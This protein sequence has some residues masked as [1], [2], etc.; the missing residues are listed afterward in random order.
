MGEAKLLIGDVFDRIEDIEPGSIDLLLTSPPFWKLRNY[1]PSDHPDKAKEIGQEPTPGEYL[2][3]MLRLV[4]RTATKLA[5]HGSVCV[6]IGDTFA[7][8][9]G[10]GGDYAEGGLRDGQPAFNGSGRTAA[11]SKHGVDP[12]RPGN[13]SS[14]TPHGGTQIPD[15]KSLCLIPTLFAAS[16]AYGRNL[17]TGEPLESGKWLV[18]NLVVWARP[19]P[20]VGDLG[21]K[22]RPGTSYMTIATR[23]RDRYFDLD[24]VRVPPKSKDDGGSM[25]N[26]KAKAAADEVLGAGGSGMFNPNGTPPLDWWEPWPIEQGLWDWWSDEVWKIVAGGYPGAHYACVDDK[27]E[28]LTPNGWKRHDELV[29]GDVI[30]AYDVDRDSWTWEPATFHRYPFAGDLVS[31][32]KRVTSQRLTPN[33][34]VIHRT[35]KLPM[36][37]QIRRADELVAGGTFLPVSAPMGGTCVDGPGAKM[38]ALAGWMITEGSIRTRQVVLYQSETANPEK[39][40]AIQELLD[41]VGAD[42][43]RR[44]RRS[45]AEFVVRGA[46]AERLRPFHK[47]L[48]WEVVATWADED[49]HALFDAM[50]DGDGHRR[51]DGRVSFIQKDR[52]T[53][54][55]FQALAIRLGYRSS[56]GW[57]K[58]SKCWICYVSPGRW[59]DLRTCTNGNGSAIGREAYTGIVWC[60]QVSTGAWVA[61]RAGKPFITGNTYPPSLCVRPIKSMC[62]E[63]VCR[64]CG[65]PSRRLVESTRYDRDG[66][67]LDSDFTQGSR[68]RGLRQT[69]ESDGGPQ[70]SH[71]ERVDLGWSDCGHDDWRSGCV[72]DPFGGSGTTA[73]VATGHGR[74]A[75]LIDLNEA[76]ADL[77]RERIG[78]FLTDI[79]EKL[80]DVPPRPIEDIPMT[81]EAML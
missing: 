30:A 6:E 70:F 76:N 56:I 66:N 44:S 2:A 42:Y 32:D 52:E 81:M 38:A 74:D 5:R 4:D 41:A 55:G 11:G 59:V 54:D 40:A 64:T 78:M 69:N 12:M 15:P 26:K 57:H 20:P 47:R 75:V 43:L 51:P 53:I 63:K 27:T 18:R 50:V 34:R 36:T 21:D 23:A 46:V 31:I 80:R 29:D 7:G 79:V 73:A 13:T 14:G 61:R 3:T 60:P 45:C 17:L 67:V 62:P 28:A 25:Q 35:T 24:A 8:S 49:V 77:C 9:G 10:A 1:I 39:V 71:V 65:E 16:L 72:F 37:S 33:H 48:P 68:E 19:N 58:R 22:F